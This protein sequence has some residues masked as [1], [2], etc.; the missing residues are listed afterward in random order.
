MEKLLLCVKERVKKCIFFHSL[1][2]LIRCTK[3]VILTNALKEKASH[4]A[5][6]ALSVIEHVESVD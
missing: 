2:G 1:Y 4:A 5:A 6:H 3:E